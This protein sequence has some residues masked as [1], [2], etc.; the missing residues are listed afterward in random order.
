MRPCSGALTFHSHACIVTLRRRWPLCSR[1]C[2]YVVP[3]LGVQ[4]DLQDGGWALHKGSAQKKATREAAG[5]VQGAHGNTHII[6][7][8]P[9][10]TRVCIAVS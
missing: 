5:H 9:D 4:V 7:P 10:G 2:M 1:R 6:V 3:A 8:E